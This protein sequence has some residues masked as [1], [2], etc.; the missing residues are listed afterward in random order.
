M[1]KMI[2]SARTQ[3]RACF[4]SMALG[5]RWHLYRIPGTDRVALM[6][7]HASWDIPTPPVFVADVQAM[8]EQTLVQKLHNK[9]VGYA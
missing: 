6:S 1:S 8:S 7:Q 5:G 4:K 9:V 2:D 3:Y